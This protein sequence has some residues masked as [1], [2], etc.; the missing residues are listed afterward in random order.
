MERSTV[1]GGVAVVPFFCCPLKFG[2]VMSD[3]EDGAMARAGN[4][5]RTV[6]VT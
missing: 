4:D 2:D 1:V 3:V 5:V 6:L